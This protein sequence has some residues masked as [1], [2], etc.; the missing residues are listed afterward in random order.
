LKEAD[1]VIELDRGA[2]EVA[3]LEQV[4]HAH[5]DLQDAFVQMA[6]LLRCGPPQQLEGLVLV[7]ELARVELVDGFGQFWWS[8]RAARRGEVRGGQAFDRP[9]ELGMG[10]ARVCR[11]QRKGYT[12]PTIF[13]WEETNDDVRIRSGADRG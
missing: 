6:N 4:V 3:L 5:A 10:R 11:G 1:A 8:R 12:A 2:M 7:E 9:G 13:A